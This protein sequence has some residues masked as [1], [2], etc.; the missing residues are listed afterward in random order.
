MYVIDL[1]FATKRRVAQVKIIANCFLDSKLVRT[2]RFASVNNH[3]SIN[4]YN[5]FN[6]CNLKTNSFLSAT[7]LR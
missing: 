2:T 3:L 5:V 6:F 4:K 1:S 7:S